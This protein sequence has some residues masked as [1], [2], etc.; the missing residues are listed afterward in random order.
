MTDSQK[1][2]INV[3]APDSIEVSTIS[4]SQGMGEVDK[5]IED[6]NSGTI[7]IDD[8]A[9]KFQRAIDI[10]E[11]LDRRIKKAKSKIDELTPRLQNEEEPF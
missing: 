7:D 8:L 9:D 3:E 4:F 5:I 10:V 2:D 1:S 11:E 6:L